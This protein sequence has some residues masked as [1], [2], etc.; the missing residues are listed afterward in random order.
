[1][2]P[3]PTTTRRP[4]AWA[5]LVAGALTVLAA[6]VLSPGWLDQLP[7]G[8][9]RVNEGVLG[10]GLR[11]DGGAATPSASPGSLFFDFDT[12]RMGGGIGTGWL[13]SSGV[14]EAVGVAAYP[15]SVDRSARLA[16]NDGA[17]PETC[18]SLEPPL[19]QVHRLSLEV[20]LDEEM[21]ATATIELRDAAGDALLTLNLAESEAMLSSAAGDLNSEA[22]GLEPGQRY[23]IEVVTDEAGAFWRVVPRLPLGSGVEMPVEWPSPGSVHEICLGAAGP[24]D[25]AVYY[26]NLAITNE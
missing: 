6:V 11:S 8:E 14:E 18:R 5:V 19:A 21:P 4:V 20:I 10:G 25:A 16:V 2:S 15:T 12:V 22:G 17:P 9:A 1:M 24:P 3:P 7:S 13:Q 23:A 26:D